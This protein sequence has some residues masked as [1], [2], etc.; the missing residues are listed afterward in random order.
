MVHLISIDPNATRKNSP[1]KQACP[2]NERVI[3]RLKMIYAVFLLTAWKHSKCSFKKR[4]RI[5]R[6]YRLLPFVNF[7]AFL[8]I[9]SPLILNT[10]ELCDIPMDK[11]RGSLAIGEQAQVVPRGKR[12]RC[13]RLSAR[14]KNT[15]AREHA[16]S[17]RE[18]AALCLRRD[19]GSTASF[20][21]NRKVNEIGHRRGDAR[22]GTVEAEWSTIHQRLSRGE[23]EQLSIRIAG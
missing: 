8:P 22:G 15:L 11:P 3:E 6:K 16:T 23:R 17:G 12:P 19:S 14:A 10:A 4:D 21:I 20:E 1:H 9:Q 2:V 7:S 18:E 5:R 13:S